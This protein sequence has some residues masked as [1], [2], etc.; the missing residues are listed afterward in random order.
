MADTKHTPG[1]WQWFE[2]ERGPY[3]ATPDRGHLYVMGLARKG[4]QGATVRFAT[5]HGIESGA[6]RERLGGIMEDGIRLRN[7]ELHPD[8][9]LLEAAPDLLAALKAVK[10]RL[11]GNG[12]SGRQL[13]EYNLI[14]AAIAKAEGGA[15]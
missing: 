1:P 8:A 6:E 13:P 3:L 12:M 2:R 10:R 11:D 4:M 7:G 9:R 14:S 5:W 15:S